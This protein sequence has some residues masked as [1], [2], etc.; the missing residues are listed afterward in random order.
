MPSC[1]PP[2]LPSSL[3][4]FLAFLAFLAPL[5]LFLPPSCRVQVDLVHFQEVYLIHRPCL[6]AHSE[7]HPVDL[8]HPLRSDLVHPNAVSLSISS[9]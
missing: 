9:R 4:P 1:L 3:P 8:V 2:F 7:P 5:L 6:S